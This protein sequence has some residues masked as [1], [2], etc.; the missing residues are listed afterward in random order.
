[1]RSIRRTLLFLLLA[2]SVL[3]KAQE[4]KYIDLS[5][6]QQ[7]TELRRPPAPPA[8]CK[9]GSGCSGGGYGGGS[10]GDCGADLRDPHALGVYLL[11]VTPTDIN[12][13]K[14]FEVE[15]KVLNTGVAPI[16]V[17]VSPHLSDLQPSD[18]SV[19]FSYLNL[20]LVVGGES[21]LQGRNVSTVGFVELYGS[22]DHDGSVLVLKPGEWIRVRANVKLNAWPLETV[23]ALF[24]GDFWLRRNTFRPH[25]GGEFTETINL[26][27]NTTPTPSI[28]VHLLGSVRSGQPKQ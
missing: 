17:P 12:P 15:F 22:T 16:E 1:M 4:I 23:S 9:E 14:P 3:L 13:A 24:R 2:W 11:R 6:I 20:A 18:E 28:A 5:L 25:P 21:Q 27:P 10:V 8:D 7:R 19:A 26:C